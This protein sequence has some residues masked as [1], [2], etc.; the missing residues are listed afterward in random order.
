MEAG[1]FNNLYMIFFIIVLLLLSPMLPNKPYDDTDV[2]T[3]VGKLIFAFPIVCPAPLN[4]PLNGV[5]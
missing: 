2:G 5:L 4:I 3:D 1:H